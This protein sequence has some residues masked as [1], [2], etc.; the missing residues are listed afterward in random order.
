MV[1]GR[2][3]GKPAEHLIPLAEHRVK[4]T[5][6]VDSCSHGRAGQ[7]CSDLRPKAAI[8]PSNPATSCRGAN[9]RAPRSPPQI[10]SARQYWTSNSTCAFK[11]HDGCHS[12]NRRWTHLPPPRDA[13]ATS[14]REASCPMSGGQ[15]RGSGR[16]CR[17]S[18]PVVER[19]VEGAVHRHVQRR[20]LR[21]LPRRLQRALTRSAPDPF[22][23][24]TRGRIAVIPH[25]GHSPFSP[26]VGGVI[27]SWVS[28]RLNRCARAPFVGG[29]GAEPATANSFG[30]LRA[31]A[32]CLV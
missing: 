21:P 9:N 11:V 5:L 19:A 26:H 10:P 27:R 20:L 23:S 4:L 12:V 30:A 28:R 15:R 14:R 8:W 32:W 3:G 7:G 6:S 31:A 18:A 29:A 2:G 1:P 25:A 13:V 24:G 17:A 16:R 22:V